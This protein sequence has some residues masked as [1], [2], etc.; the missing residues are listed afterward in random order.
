MFM[1]IENKK[2][3]QIVI[4]QIQEMIMRGELKDGDQ[5]PPERIM[6]EQFQIGRPAL[7][8]ALK[9][10][11]VLGLVERRH[12]LGNY[13]VNNV[14]SNFFKPLSL[15]FK[16]SNGNVQEILQLRYLIETFTVRE[17]AK[18]ATFDDISFLNQKQKEMME[19]ET[20]D[21]KSQC[22]KDI[23]FKIA[24]ICNNSLILATFENAS[25]LL[26][27]FIDQAVHLS[28]FAE[29]DS[30]ERIYE[31]HKNI[32][33]AIEKK[34]ADLAVSFINIHLNNIRPDLLHG[35]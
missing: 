13:I 27:N 6:T 10:L 1:A 32:I 26:E 28:Y 21:E 18:L 9:A 29:E 19:A 14:E 2:I 22:D 34:D 30:V 11:E 20:P 4:E 25:Y 31:E 33:D 17:A 8:E 35:I 24:R 23:H 12:G 7:R 16:L 15:S 3:S 5:L